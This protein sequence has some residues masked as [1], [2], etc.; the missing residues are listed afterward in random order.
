MFVEN[1]CA[2]MPC[3]CP[4]VHPH[5]IT[6]LKDDPDGVVLLC[7]VRLAAEC[8]HGHHNAQHR[9]ITANIVKGLWGGWVCTLTC[10]HALGDFP[11]LPA[12]IIGELP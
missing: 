4:S 11:S 3:G 6:N 12:T 8:L 9:S 5:P 10:R 2:C 1:Q 7:T